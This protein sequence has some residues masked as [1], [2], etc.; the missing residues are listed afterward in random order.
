MAI[1]IHIGKARY[2]VTNDGWDQIN[3]CL[4]PEADTRSAM[5]RLTIRGHN[6]MRALEYAIKAKLIV[7]AIDGVLE[8]PPAPELRKIIDA[9]TS[10]QAIA[11]TIGGTE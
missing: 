1:G 3:A 8:I 2:E 10:M 5:T 11:P 9:A 7:A 4:G 6:T